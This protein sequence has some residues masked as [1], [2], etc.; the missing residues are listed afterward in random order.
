MYKQIEDKKMPVE[1]NKWRQHRKNPFERR[2]TSA[3]N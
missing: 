2:Y 3:I 1:L